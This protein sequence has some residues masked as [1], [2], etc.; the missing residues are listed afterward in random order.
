M[1]K[2]QISILMSVFNAENTI[3]QSIDS[4]L[5]Q[6]YDQW[7]FI[8]CD[9]CSTDHTLQILN[10]YK[11]KY[12]EKFLIIRNKQNMRLAASLNHCLK[13]AD[14]EYCA[15]MDADDYISPVRFE[16]QIEY[17][18]THSDVV[19]VGTLMQA[20]NEK[21]ELGRIIYYKEKPTKYDLRKGPVF[22]HA[23]ILTYT[24]VYKEIG[25]Y[26]VSSRTKR[27]QDYDLWFKFYEHGFKGETIQEPLY[28]VREDENAFM[29]RTRKQYL[30]A[31]VT[32]W[33]GFR[34]LHYPLRYYVYVLTPIASLI[35]NEI[36]KF[37]AKLHCI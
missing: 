8:I 30:W 18:N 9:D 13:Y 36:R 31:I 6:T 22:C 35:K 25:G 3:R 12:P 34:R 1:V 28:F 21:N 33:I 37:Q 27:S 4:V 2:G 14:G 15:R 10:E 7:K 19:L 5:A 20:F 23:S 32:R 26:T 11:K 24:R 17:L 29:R 16:K